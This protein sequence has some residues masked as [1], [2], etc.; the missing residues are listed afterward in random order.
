MRCELDVTTS[1]CP[2]S[3]GGT[4][5]SVGNRCRRP[6]GGWG[7]KW[8]VRQCRPLAKTS[9]SRRLAVNGSHTVVADG[10]G[11]G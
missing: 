2:A 1:R 11:T 10:E 6:C 8:E 9:L 4:T 3:L 7:G 5:V